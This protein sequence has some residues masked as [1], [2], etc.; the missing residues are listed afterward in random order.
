MSSAPRRVTQGQPRIAITKITPLPRG[1]AR[2]Q[3]RVTPTTL[4]RL[5]FGHQDYV[6]ANRI[7]PGGRYVITLSRLI[8][9]KPSGVFTIVASSASAGRFPVQITYSPGYRSENIVKR[10]TVQRT[11][12]FSRGG[13]AVRDRHGEERTVRAG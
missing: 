5:P 13:T 4:L 3:G 9:V 1:R 12:A 7:A 2:I 10:T 8:A 11:I 6:V